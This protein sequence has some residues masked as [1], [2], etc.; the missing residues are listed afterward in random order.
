MGYSNTKTATGVGTGYINEYASVLFILSKVTGM[1]IADIHFDMY[2]YDNEEVYY[3]TRE[4]SFFG[5]KAI[6]TVLDEFDSY[7]EG[8]VG[9]DTA[10]VIQANRD[11]WANHTL[12]AF[13]NVVAD[14]GN[15]N[16]KGDIVLLKG[17]EVVASYSL[18]YGK[19]TSLNQQGDSARSIIKHFGHFGDIT[20]EADH[21]AYIA[22]T[23]WVG[24]PMDMERGEIVVGSDMDKARISMLNAY[25]T[26]LDAVGEAFV[27]ADTDAIIDHYFDLATGGEDNTTQ[28]VIKAN[29]NHEVK[30]FD[31]NLRTLLRERIESGPMRYYAVWTDS[32]KCVDYYYTN[33]N[34]TMRVS[35]QAK[36]R[37]AGKG[38][39]TLEH[40]AYVYFTY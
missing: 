31:N 12:P 17:D 28:I 18:K 2:T 11:Y 1:D 8:E 29:G 19:A 34:Y 9:T 10:K 4:V 7:F 33:D 3:Q 27:S 22:K 20:H 40:N 37:G 24:V 6:V 15:R 21:Y 32:G 14:G 13:D 23:S 16:N 35:V 36:T 5:S 39:R 30:V 25:S 38:V 26:V